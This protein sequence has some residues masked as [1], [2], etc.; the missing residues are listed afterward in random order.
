MKN[1]L[2][3]KILSAALVLALTIPLA[4]CDIIGGKG[5]DGGTDL[6]GGE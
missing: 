4:G 1:I 6:L 5:N 3:K 2:V